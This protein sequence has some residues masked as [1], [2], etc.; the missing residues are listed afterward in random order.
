M[1]PQHHVDRAGEVAAQASA[2]RAGRAAA[3][4]TPRTGSPSGR[5]RSSSGARSPSRTAAAARRVAADVAAGERQLEVHLAQPVGQRHLAQRR[6]ASASGP[7]AASRRRRPA[8][9]R[10][11]RGRARPATSRAARR[12]GRAARR[13]GRAASGS[14]CSSTACTSEPNV[15]PT[16]RPGHRRGHVRAVAVAAV[17][18]DRHG[19]RLE[20]LVVLA[21]HLRLAGDRAPTPGRPR[22]TALS[23]EYDVRRHSVST[24]RVNARAASAGAGGA[25][26]GRRRGGRLARAPASGRR[27]RATART[28]RPPRR[29]PGP[30]AG[31]AP[32]GASAS[33][34]SIRCSGEATAFLVGAHQQ[35]TWDWARVIATYSS[36]SHSPASSS[37]QRRQWSAQSAPPAADVEAA[38]A[39]VVVEERPV[40]F[41]TY[42][43]ATAGR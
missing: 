16:G 31:P 23:E 11:P 2:R 28:A 13:A 1:H 36:R 17:A 8:R 7:P 4:R 24:V 38:L 5:C 32:R 40:G 34:I 14:V 22:P 10:A 26:A 3:R 15:A 33:R 6:P 27:G 21:D 35:T 29:R 18:R 12:C 25:G 9:R 39:V 42:R 41:G 37:A 30:A 19:H 20:L 43:S